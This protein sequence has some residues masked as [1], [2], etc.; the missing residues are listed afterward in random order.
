VKTQLQKAKKS[1]NIQSNL[2]KEV[3]FVTMKTLCYKTGSL[4]LPLIPSIQMTA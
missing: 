3:T 2:F 1:V 4:F